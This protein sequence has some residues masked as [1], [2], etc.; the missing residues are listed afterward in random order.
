MIFKKNFQ[1]LLLFFPIAILIFLIALGFDGLYGQDGYEYARYAIKLREFLLGGEFPGDVVWPKVY[2]FIL[3]TFSLALP[4][5]LAGQLISLLA[6]YACYYF[7]KKT[8]SLLY[9]SNEKAEPFLLIAFLLSPYILRL[10]VVVMAD[11][12]AMLSVIATAYYYFRYKKSS[13]LVDIALCVLWGT[14]GVFSRYA[15][16][17]PI[18]PFLLW[19]MVHWLGIKKWKHLVVLTIPIFVFFINLLLEGSGSKFT[20]HHLIENWSF[21]N[22][23]KSEFFAPAGLEI[24]NRNYL[25]PNGIFYFFSFFHPGFFVLLGVAMLVNIKKLREYLRLSPSPLIISIILYSIFLSG[26]TFQGNR[27]IALSYPLFLIFS[28]PAIRDFIERL[29]KNYA[30]LIVGCV[31][32]QLTLFVRAMWPSY[33]M[34]ETERNLVAEMEPFEGSVLYSFEVDISMQQRGLDFQYISLWKEEIKDFQSGALVVFN[35]PRIAK[36]YT[37]KNPMKNWNR[38]QQ[39]YSLNP[40]KK[41]KS[42]WTLYKIEKR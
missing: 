17:V 37:D 5:S 11:T 1:N 21:L 30:T 28:F 18:A 25:L 34:N 15:V 35:E 32:L 26:I 9:G 41:M 12:F 39:D 2:L 27:Y 3:A 7:L 14:L 33:N 4:I 24:S 36:L 19:A 42:G 16:L 13:K 20:N 29:K 10:S 31:L 40:I 6:F 23:F 22:L 38:L 8:I